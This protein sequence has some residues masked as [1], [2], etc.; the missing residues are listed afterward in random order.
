MIRDRENPRLVRIVPPPKFQGILHELPPIRRPVARFA[1]AF[2]HPLLRETIHGHYA[3]QWDSF[4]FSIGLTDG[5]LQEIRLIVSFRVDSPG[6]RDE[7]FCVNTSQVQQTPGSSGKAPRLTVIIVN[8]NGWPDLLQL[9]SA[10]VAE[11]E[12]EPGELQVVV[13]DNASPDPIPERL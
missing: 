12:F 13:V 5:I 10:L 11:P 2:G 9:V 6:G 4:K 1:E 8:Y 3:I 7:D